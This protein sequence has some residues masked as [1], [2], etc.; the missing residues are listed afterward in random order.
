MAFRVVSKHRSPA[1]QHER[2]RLPLLTHESSP[3]ADWLVRVRI[4]SYL[5]HESRGILTA[6]INLYLFLFFSGF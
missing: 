5:R 6:R 3:V 2:S 1:Y 4:E